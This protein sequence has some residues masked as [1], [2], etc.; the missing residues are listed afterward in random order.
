MG[1]RVAPVR[2]RIL[3]RVIMIFSVTRKPAT[4]NLSTTKAQ[5]L[6]CP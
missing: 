1:A 3:R 4:Q 5:G 6:I 2:P